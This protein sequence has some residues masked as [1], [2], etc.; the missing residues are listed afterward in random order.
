[1]GLRH[2]RSVLSSIRE[3]LTEHDV[4]ADFSTI[5]LPYMSHVVLNMH[6]E[7]AL[8]VELLSCGLVVAFRFQTVVY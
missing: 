5:S 7:L 3:F 2:F 4:P 6:A 8:T 1:M